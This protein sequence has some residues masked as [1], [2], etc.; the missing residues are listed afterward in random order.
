MR[1]FTRFQNTMHVFYAIENHMLRDVERMLDQGLPIETKKMSEITLLHAA[2][3]AHDVP[4]AR[5]LLERGADP[6][7]IVKRCFGCAWRKYN[8]LEAACMEKDFEMVRLL[9]E[10]GGRIEQALEPAVHGGSFEIVK[11]LIDK[12]ANVNFVDPD[13][14]YT[15]LYRAIREDRID[16][17]RLLVQNGADIHVATVQFSYETPLAAAS[18]KNL[19]I[20]KFLLESGARINDFGKRGTSPLHAAVGAGKADIVDF[21]LKNGA[22]PTLTS[23]FDGMTPLHRACAKPN[24]AMV[25]QLLQAGVHVNIRTGVSEKKDDWRLGSTPLIVL[26]RDTFQEKSRLEVLEVLLEFFADIEAKDFMGWNALQ[27]SIKNSYRGSD[28]NFPI[29]L[30]KAGAN[31]HVTDNQGITPLHWAARNELHE[32][33]RALVQHGADRNANDKNGQIPADFVDCRRMIIHQG[34]DFYCTIHPR[35]WVEKQVDLY[36]FLLPS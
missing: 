2:I 21:L 30:M 35:A 3:E 14:G 19:E 9:Q 18:Y 26:A 10:K 7:A 13:H 16:L 36:L 15:A 31:V 22:D 17:V 12:G 32:V 8:A 20:V 33:A 27:L 29:R 23:S 34:G 4:I 5:M 28:P 11:Y 25:R 24:A 6:S 1:S